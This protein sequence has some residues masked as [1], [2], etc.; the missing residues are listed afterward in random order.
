VELRTHCMPAVCEGCN[1]AHKCM[2]TLPQP[3]RACGMVHQCC[4]IP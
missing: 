3:A 4:Q 1:V 2:T